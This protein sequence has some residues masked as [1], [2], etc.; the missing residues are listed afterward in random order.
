MRAKIITSLIRALLLFAS[1]SNFHVAKAEPTKPNTEDPI[2]IE[3]VSGESGKK[4][5]IVTIYLNKKPKIN[6][7]D[8]EAHG[9]FL[10]ISLKNTLVPKPGKFYDISSPYF[11]KMVLIQTENNEAIVRIFTTQEASTISKATDIDILNKRIVLTADHNYLA[12]LLAKDEEKQATAKTAQAVSNTNSEVNK[13]KVK[14]SI[15]DKNPNTPFTV[16]TESMPS[17]LLAKGSD[18]SFQSKLKVAAYF[19]IAMIL[20]LLFSL[21]WRRIAINR[22]LLKPRSDNIPMQALNHLVLAPKQKLSLVQVGHEKLLLSVSP[23]GISLITHIPEKNRPVSPKSNFNSSDKEKMQT[24]M[25]RNIGKQ[26]QQLREA[27]KTRSNTQ[28]NKPPVQTMNSTEVPSGKV[29]LSQTSSS[30]SVRESMTTSPQTSI[31]KKIEY[32]ID[33]NGVRKTVKKKPVNPQG[34][35]TQ[36]AIDDVTQLIREKLK[37]LPKI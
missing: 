12:K 34:N 31:P 37:S 8:L 21:T 2:A 19:S 28:Q 25:M 20:L 29:N 4:L 33:D 24:I 11:N 26:Q 14:Q 13:E 18:N 17:N 9:T 23:E 27:E 36:K 30:N 35:T 32:A 16:D 15:K 1:T 10:Q 22:K 3:K 7:I 6:K 5:S